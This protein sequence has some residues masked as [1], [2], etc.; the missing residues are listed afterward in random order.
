MAKWWELSLPVVGTLAGALAGALIQG[1]NNRKQAKDQAQHQRDIL[2]MSEKVQ[3][4][5]QRD[6]MLMS[7]KVKLYAELLRILNAMV[8]AGRRLDDY[9]RAWTET[10]TAL[11][12]RGEVSPEEEQQLA[13]LR[14]T[15]ESAR[16]ELA[17]LYDKLGHLA[18][19]IELYAPDDVVEAFLLVIADQRD[20]SRIFNLRKML[21]S[22][23]GVTKR[24][25][26]DR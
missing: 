4:Q 16:R 15:G 19:A 1:W 8:P 6:M 10:K 18:D 5:H 26:S 2:L 11:K 20:G 14:V 7:E 3:A 13:S 24:V 22:D 25:A 9:H 21:R 17:P 12:A 23:L